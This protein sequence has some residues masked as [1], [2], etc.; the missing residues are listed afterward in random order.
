MFGMTNQ[1]KQMVKYLKQQFKRGT[2]VVCCSMADPYAPIPSGMTGTV[3]S[4]D[5]SGTIHM[6]W[7]NGRTL[8]IIYGV[9]QFNII[10]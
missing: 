6:K 9:D 1:E 3:T 8:G 5:D 7:D 4:V 10:N 2:R